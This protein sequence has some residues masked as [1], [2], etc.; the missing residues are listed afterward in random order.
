MER[1]C[2]LLMAAVAVLITLVHEPVVGNGP[3][4]LSDVD[5]RIERALRKEKVAGAALVLVDQQGLV[6]TRG[7]G[8]AHRKKRQPFTAKTRFPF[9]NITHVITAIAV[10]KLVEDGK[11]GLDDPLS[12]L[13]PELALENRFNGAAPP[14]LRQLLSHHSGLPSNV[15]AGYY[16]EEPQ[17]QLAPLPATLYLAQPPGRIYGYSN[18]AYAVLGHIV[19]AHSGRPYTEYVTEQVLKPL[20][21]RN[22]GFAA[23]PGDA[24]GHDRKRKPQPATYA[25]NVAALGLYGTAEDLSRLLQFA[26]GSGP[27]QVLGA[28][29]RAEMV[30]PQNADVPL[31]LDNVAGLGWQLTNT[32]GF[33]VDRVLRINANTLHF[34]SNLVALPDQ[35]LGIALVTNS[36]NGVDFVVDQSREVMDEW[37]E[38]SAGVAPPDRDASGFSDQIPLPTRASAAAMDERYVT[39]LGLIDFEGKPDRYK[40]QFLGR[41][42]RAT[43]RD[44]GWYEMAY[45][46][47]GIF[48]IQFNIMEEILL[49][50]AALGGERVLLALY[51]GQTFL[52]GT[53]LPAPGPTPPALARLTGR[54]EIANP[55]FFSEQ[56]KLDLVELKIED[57]QL[58]AEY[59]LPIFFR[60]TPKIPLSPGEADGVLFIPGLGTG[61]GERVRFNPA[62]QTMTFSGYQFLRRN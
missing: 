28:T 30:R 35:G 50:P 55:D 31:D 27:D 9:A 32:E 26:L 14:T 12:R 49:R 5:A 16:A 7:Y 51:Q 15:L 44:D 37:L 60:L 10:L 42:F 48:D 56:L 45:R 39:P 58:V 53:A 23:T 13:L 4:W 17:G 19:E 1:M 47:L 33:A 8:W 22:T 18:L 46:L 52:L 24:T 38:R 2:R 43:R 21:M 29:L 20:G 3:D 25:S 41:G 59:R 36:A 11:I 61:L 62:E 57:G 34:R 40:M 6:H 54:Y